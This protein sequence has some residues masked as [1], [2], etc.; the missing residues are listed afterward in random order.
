LMGRGGYSKG[1]LLYKWVFVIDTLSKNFIKFP[2][3]KP[4]TSTKDSR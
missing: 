4:G 2:K 3:I 1:G